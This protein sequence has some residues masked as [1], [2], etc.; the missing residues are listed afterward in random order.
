MSSNPNSFGPYLWKQIHLAA[1][2]LDMYATADA[3]SLRKGEEPK[4]TE[5][6]AV[7]H[8]FL[9][10]IP[11]YVPCD[12]CEKHVKSFMFQ[13]PVPPMEPPVEDSKLFFHWSCDCHNHANSITGKRMIPYEEAEKYYT[14][15]YLENQ[16]LNE[17]QLARMHDSN[18]IKILEGQI[19][20]M[21]MNGPPCRIDYRPLTAVSCLCV[22]FALIAL[23][24]FLKSPR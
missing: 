16:K 19:E 13:F 15:S 17:H 20:S 1:K 8:K 24:L 22:M 7:L 11:H 23:F 10:D 14:P 3:I 12:M 9:V 21:K 4:F 2:R 6:R 5:R 18:Q